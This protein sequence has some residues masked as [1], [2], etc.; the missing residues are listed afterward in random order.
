MSSLDGRERCPVEWLNSARRRAM[1]ATKDLDA[2][3]RRAREESL[4]LR[5]ENSRLRRENARL[6]AQPRPL[7]AGEGPAFQLQLLGPSQEEPVTD[8]SSDANRISLFRKL[9]RGR[10]D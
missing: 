1:T 5:E 3:L 9:F 8:Y 6:R 7:P 4:Q 2:E 10:E